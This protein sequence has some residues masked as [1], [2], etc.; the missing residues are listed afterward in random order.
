MHDNGGNERCDE[1]QSSDEQVQ[2]QPLQA[3]ELFK[4]C[5]FHCG[6]SRTKKAFTA[7]RAMNDN[8]QGAYVSL[9]YD[10]MTQQVPRVLLSPL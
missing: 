8:M 3:A 4:Q 2:L 6:S 5:K 7:T 10:G 9:S 1:R